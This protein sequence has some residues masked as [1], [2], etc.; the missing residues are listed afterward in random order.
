MC[1]CYVY[2]YYFNR[3]WK[4]HLR[5]VTKDNQLPIYQTLCI[6]EAEVDI[7]EFE[8]KMSQF[9]SH[10]ELKETEFIKYFKEYYKERAGT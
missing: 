3:A 10:W 2:M 6:L 7:A 5:S 4:K 8:F 1:A 9:I